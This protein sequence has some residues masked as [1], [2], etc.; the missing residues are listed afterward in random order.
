MQ[1]QKDPN[2]TEEV[3]EGESL[4]SPSVEETPDSPDVFDEYPDEPHS[5]DA[6]SGEDNDADVIIDITPSDKK[7]R[8]RTFRRRLH[9]FFSIRDDVASHEKIRERIVSGG[10][11]TGTNASILIF[12]IL[13]ACVG[14][15]TN[16][17]PVVIGAMLISPLMGTLMAISYGAIS[18]DVRFTRDAF[19]G[20]FFQFLISFAVATLFFL[21]SPVKEPSQELLNRT[22]PTVFDIVIAFCGG[23]AGMIAQTRSS[24]YSN[25]IPGVAIATA[26]MPPVCTMGYSLAN[27]Q[28]QMLAGS[29]V[30]FIINI[31]CIFAAGAIVLGFLQIPR[32][33][34][35]TDKK[36]KL[37]RFAMIRNGIIIGLPAIVLVVLVSIGIFAQ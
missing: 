26:L 35:V 24:K 23:A 11:I 15:N 2:L 4:E 25:V 31:Y 29:S 30:L 33:T 19:V 21:I 20:F 32:V 17:I 12:A 3:K 18:A 5:I 16:S 13:I 14:L 27:G 9:S 8:H 1:E 34:P 36:W 37:L 10:K 22:T 28:W 6:V 7:V